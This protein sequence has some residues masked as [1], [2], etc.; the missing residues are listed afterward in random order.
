MMLL[1]RARSFRSGFR[2][3]INCFVGAALFV[4]SGLLLCAGSVGPSRLPI[5]A[6]SQDK[7][8]IE[9]SEELGRLG[10]LNWAPSRMSA[11]NNMACSRNFSPAH[12]RAR[13]TTTSKCSSKV[14]QVI[15]GRYGCQR[16]TFKLGRK[17]SKRVSEQS[18]LAAQ[19]RSAFGM[20]DAIKSHNAD[21]LVTEQ[22][23]CI[24]C[25]Q[26]AQ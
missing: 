13:K 9:S 23:S 14:V 7:T 17:T 3:G 16:L 11:A 22:D 21:A 15:T 18:S 1:S 4:A 6:G 12:F 5:G 8:I 20:F 10:P 24:M 25:Y 19:T 2:G 26:Q